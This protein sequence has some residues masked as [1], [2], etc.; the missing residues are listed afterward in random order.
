M[1][2]PSCALMLTHP[3]EMGELI[4]KYKASVAAGTTDQI[5]IQ[6]QAVTTQELEA[7]RNRAREQL[8]EAEQRVEHMRGESVSVGA[9]R[10]VELR[11]R[12]AL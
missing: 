6:N 1:C 3:Q 4:K 2:F 12:Q 10:R 11:V 7:Q 9:H 5:T 8:A